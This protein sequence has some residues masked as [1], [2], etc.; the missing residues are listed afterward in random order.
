MSAAGSS[1]RRDYPLRPLRLDAASAHAE[2]RVTYG[3][4]GV[5]T[6]RDAL[7]PRYGLP[8]TV[9]IDPAHQF[10]LVHACLEDLDRALRRAP[11][12]PLL[13][14]G[15]P[16]RELFDEEWARY[17]RLVEATQAQGGVEPGYGSYVFDHHRGDLYLVAPERW[18]RLALVASNA[19]LITDREQTLSSPRCGRGSRAPWSASPG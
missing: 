6:L 8:E 3:S 4:D 1:D 15:R 9:R 11:S 13:E 19:M 7:L 18:H 12:S 17:Q 14:G 2:G 5:V 16:L 10:P